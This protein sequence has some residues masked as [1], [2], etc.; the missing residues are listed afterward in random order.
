MMT[1]LDDRRLPVGYSLFARYAFPPNEL[2]YCGPA[3]ADVLLRGDD[4]AEVATHAKAFDGAWPYLRAIAE[5]AG[6][7]DALDA[8]VVRSYWVGGPLLDRVDSTA[9]LT[10]LRNAFEGQATGLLSD[11]TQPNGSLAHHS[12][13]VFVV[14]PWVNFLDRAAPTAVKVLQDCRIRW[15]T[16]ECVE[17]EHAVMATRPLTFVDGALR[18]GEPRSERVRWSRDGASLIGPPAPGEVITAHWDWACGVLTE[19]ECMSLVDATQTTLDLVNAART[20]ER[21]R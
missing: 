5:A 9:L 17:D 11:L 10:R 3:D 12:F 14:Y 8:D 16:V 1:A 7:Q 19:E 18:L 6:T 21:N 4:P 2:G 15:G 13:H 20:E